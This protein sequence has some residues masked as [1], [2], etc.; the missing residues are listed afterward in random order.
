MKAPRVALF[1]DSFHEVNGAAYTCRQYQAFAERRGLPLLVVHSGSETR[2]FR[3]GSVSTIELKRSRATVALDSD[4]GF[5]PL[6]W[7]YWSRLGKALAAFQPDLVHI[8]SPGDFGFLGLCWAYRLGIPIVASFHTNL[9][10][11]AAARLQ[12]SLRFLPGRPRQ[13]ICRCVEQVGGFALGKFYQIPRLLLAPNPEI[14]QWLERATGRP[15][16][17]MGRGVDIELFHPARRDVAADGA[18]RMGYVGRLT[19]EKNLRLLAALERALLE[20]GLTRYLFV[21]V[22][23]G[24]ERAWLE[25]NLRRAEFT[26]VLRGEPLARAYANFDLFLFPSRTDAFGNVVQEALAAG[27]PALVTRQGGPKFLIQP[28]ITGYVAADDH[29]FIARAVSLAAEPE[30]CRRMRAAARQAACALSWDQIFEQVW[31]DYQICLPPPARKAAVL[32]H[33]RLES[34]NAA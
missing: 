26:G 28:G 4:L 9:H 2:S 34:E 29:E 18:F 13:A 32:P 20:A 12:K 6:L 11:F 5:D 24:S 17:P 16:R 25:E 3:Q 10:E 33:P 15:C 31:E 19:R 14:Q 23:G 1:A 7:R 21:I 27:T 22:G 8:I 30:V